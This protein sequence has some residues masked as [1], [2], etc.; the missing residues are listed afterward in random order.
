MTLTADEEVSSDAGEE[1]AALSQ[2]RH[3]T[4]DAPKHQQHQAE[5]QQDHYDPVQVWETHK[6]L[7]HA[8]NSRV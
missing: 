3:Q 6:P 2:R 4:E 8:T 5:R 1:R 7:L